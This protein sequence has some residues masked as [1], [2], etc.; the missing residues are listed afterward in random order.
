MFFCSAQL[1]NC[2]A[3]WFHVNAWLWALWGLF[4]SYLSSSTLNLCTPLHNWKPRYRTET[5]V[6]VVVLPWFPIVLLTL[7][8]PVI[9]LV[10]RCGRQLWTSHPYMAIIKT[11]VIPDGSADKNHQQCRSRRRHSFNPWVRK[12]PWRGA[13]SPAYSNILAWRIPWT[14]EPG[15]LQSR[16]SRRV[17]HDWNSLAHRQAF[18]WWFLQTKEELSQKPPNNLLSL[19]GQWGINR[20]QDEWVYHDCFRWINSRNHMAII[21]C[22]TVRKKDHDVLHPGPKP[23]IEL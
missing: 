9:K 17:G 5:W 14:E 21:L 10:A 22:R 23:T 13:C 15:E 8:F 7:G 12:I 2:S 20:S 19:S 3:V 4:I 18:L 1:I 11:K 16:G 6:N